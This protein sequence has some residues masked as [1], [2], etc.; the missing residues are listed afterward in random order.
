M[1]LVLVL[2]VELTVRWVVGPVVVASKV[3]AMWSAVWVVLKLAPPLVLRLP[4]V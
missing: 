3:T 2:L 4:K 1:E